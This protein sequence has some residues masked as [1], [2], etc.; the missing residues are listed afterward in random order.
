MQLSAGGHRI[1]RRHNDAERGCSRKCR[2]YASSTVSAPRSAG[3]VCAHFWLVFLGERER[4]RQQPDLLSILSG[5]RANQR[6]EY[7]MT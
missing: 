1:Q 7:V 5:E 4:V 3:T 2:R 6:T